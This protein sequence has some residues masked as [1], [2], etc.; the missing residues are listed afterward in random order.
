MRRGDLLV[1]RAQPAHREFVIAVATAAYARGARHV[2]TEIEDP[3]V[4]AARFRSGAK[5]TP[6]PYLI[7][8]TPEEA[9]KRDGV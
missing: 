7:P 5:M 8:G 9:A 1:V 6:V 4:A 3:L 2:E